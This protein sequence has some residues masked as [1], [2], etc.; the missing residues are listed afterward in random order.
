MQVMLM[1][2]IDES[3]WQALP[4]A[5]RDAIMR[6]YRGWVGEMERLGKH[7][8]TAKLEPS[9]RA[10]TIR[11]KNGARHVV[12]GPFAETKEQFGGYHLL[13]CRDLDEALALA[14]RIPTL[15]ARRCRRGPRAGAR[16]LN[17]AIERGLSRGIPARA[18]DPDPP[19]RRFRPRRGGDARGVRRG[20]RAMAAARA[21]RRTRAPGWSRPGASRRS[22]RCAGG[23]ASSALGDDAR[24]RS[25]TMPRIPPRRPTTRSS[26]DRLRLI[27]TCCHP[28]LRRRR[29]GGAD[30][31]RG[32]RPD[33]RG[34]RRAFL[35]TPATLA[36]R[37]VRAKAKIRDARIPYEVPPAAE[38]PERLDA[39]LRV[40]YLVFNEGYAASAGDSL[41]RA[42][43]SAEAIRL[44][45]LLV[46]LLPEPE[47]AGLLALMLLQ[48]SRRAARTT[49]DRR[50]RAARRPGP[51]AVESRRR[52]AKAS[53]SCERALASRRFGPYT[54]QAAIAAAHA[55]GGDRGGH[56]LGADRGH[57]RPAARHRA[58]A[59]HRAQPRRCDRD[60]R[61][62]GRRA[63]T[64]RRDPGARRPRATTSR[65]TPRAPTSAAGSAAPATRE[66]P[67]GARSS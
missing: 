42:D 18:R 63:R 14:E 57:L 56:R 67:T 7:V 23:R 51:L 65:R 59:G 37:I 29:A 32:L 52:S 10:Q 30:A 19:A 28:A 21:C 38:L 66:N 34:D 16:C 60:A 15:R 40:I 22:T 12:D 36:Q 20:A 46:E 27:F 62:A 44:G 13:E 55:A 5:S 43:L 26:D 17:E 25:R 61:R 2:C 24:R 35:A 31:A 64:D 11:L 33:D 3:R 39:V 1:C 45:R 47:A 48:D 41:T 49:G 54:L 50:H 9:A 4:A 6:D 8:A 58:L 53:R